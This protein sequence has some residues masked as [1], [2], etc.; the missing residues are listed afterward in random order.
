MS[1]THAP[2]QS[3][4]SVQENGRVTIHQLVIRERDGEEPEEWIVTGIET[5]DRDENI[6][7]AD[8]EFNFRLSVSKSVFHQKGFKECVSEDG[9]PV[10]G[11]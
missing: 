9:T 2:M 1:S 10:W 4:L 3:S 6:V 7:L 5:G 8:P 11:Y